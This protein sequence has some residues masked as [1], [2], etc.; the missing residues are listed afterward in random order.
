MINQIIIKNAI[1]CKHCGD[2]IESMS[3]HDFVTCSCGKVSIDGGHCYLKRCCESMDDYEDLS[4]VENEDETI[5]VK[6]N[7]K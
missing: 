4:I 1:K 5:G 6:E 3:V 2:V 7:G